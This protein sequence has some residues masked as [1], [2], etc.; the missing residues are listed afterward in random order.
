MSWFSILPAHLTIVETWLIRIFLL[1]GLL[2][3]GPWALLIFYDLLLWLFR[4]ILY[5]VPY[6]GGRARG[7]K[8][9]RAPSLSERPSGRART[10]SIGGTQY[11]GMESSEKEGI[12]ERLLDTILRADPETDDGKD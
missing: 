5:I 12:K 2:T 8:R 6:V 10:F 7:K 3:I 9:P 11:A 4:S 1:L